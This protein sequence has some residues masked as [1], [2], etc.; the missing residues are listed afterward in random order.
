MPK[1]PVKP[2][3]TVKEIDLD[4]LG[5]T[6]SFYIRALSL[7]VSRDLDECLNGL[8]VAKGTGKITTLL[9][10]DSHPGIRPSVIA[11]LTMKDRS[12]M[13]RI[14]DQME[15]HHLLRRETSSED[16]RAQELYIT[17]T[18]AALAVKIRE[19]VPKQSREFFDFIPENEQQQLM[20][21]LRRAYRRIVGLSE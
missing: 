8:D 13:G 4:V 17:E 6:L 11:H 18:G 21:I 2:P 9:L 1:P 5:D 14:I 19:L 12:A 7:A 16:N 20:D 3:T 10:V 15:A